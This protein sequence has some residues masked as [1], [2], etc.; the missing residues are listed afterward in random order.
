MKPD[1]EQ[2]PS[3]S[4]EI[5]AVRR[6]AIFSTLSWLIGLGVLLIYAFPTQTQSFLLSLFSKTIFLLALLFL[7]TLAGALWACWAISPYALEYVKKRA[8]KLGPES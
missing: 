2:N 1:Q 8:G 7:L 4:D 6:V 3:L 5:Q